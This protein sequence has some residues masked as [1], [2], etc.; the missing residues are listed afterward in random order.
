MVH[1]FD[2]LF[3]KFI[4]VVSILVSD[5]VKTC[6]ADDLFLE[7]FVQIQALLAPDENVDDFDV[8]EREK[9][10]LEEDFTKE[11]RCTSNED[12]LASVLVDNCHK[13]LNE[14]IIKRYWWIK[15]NKTDI[16]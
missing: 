11:A 12:R 10:F 15:E 13:K 5:S 2:F 1:G 16:K 9:E 3:N 6:A 8:R 7:S 4:K 14:F